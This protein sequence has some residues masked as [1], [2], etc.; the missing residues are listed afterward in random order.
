MT[1]HVRPKRFFSSFV[2]LSRWFSAGRDNAV[3]LCFIISYYKELQ[4]I[5]RY[6]HVCIYMR[7]IFYL[8]WNRGKCYETS[9]INPKLAH[10]CRGHCVVYSNLICEYPS[11]RRRIYTETKANCRRC[12]LGENGHPHASI[13]TV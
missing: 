9:S 6:V 4:R 1:Q 3:S 12:F 5:L 10:H 7:N 2:I 11:H 8:P 13:K